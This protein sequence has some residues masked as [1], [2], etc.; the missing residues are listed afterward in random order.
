MV[1]NFAKRMQARYNYSSCEC[2]SLVLYFLAACPNI[3]GTVSER[4]MNSEQFHSMLLAYSLATLF[5][6]YMHSSP[7]KICDHI[8]P[9]LNCLIFNIRL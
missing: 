2:G 1:C 3:T 9:E 6:S 7:Y 8:Q 5:D 4:K